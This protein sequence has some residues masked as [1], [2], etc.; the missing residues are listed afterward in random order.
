MEIFKVMLKNVRIVCFD[1]IVNYL[2]TVP[3]GN[4]ML[5]RN[6]VTSASA[7][8]TFS[9]ARYIKNWMLLTMLPS[10]INSLAVLKFH[11]DRTDSIDLLKVANR[12]VHNENRMNLF[13][14]LFYRKRFLSIL[15]DTIIFF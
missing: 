12:F 8:R 11:K 5:I 1:D 13:G 3:A 10:K 14:R 4:L 7:E 2:Q 6:V 15:H 9:M